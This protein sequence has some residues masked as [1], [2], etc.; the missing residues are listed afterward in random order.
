[1]FI[2]FIM[3]IMCGTDDYNVWDRFLGRTPKKKCGRDLKNV[4]NDDNVDIFI[5]FIMF[6][7]FIYF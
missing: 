6:I 5:I 7:M 4:Y 1:M 2:T 3:F